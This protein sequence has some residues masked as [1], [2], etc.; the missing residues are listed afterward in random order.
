MYGPASI[1]VELE[2]TIYTVFN[3][4][5]TDVKI[6]SAYRPMF[7]MEINVCIRR[8]IKQYIVTLT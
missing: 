1:I 5:K 8:K 3:Y 2:R 6:L 4:A 7:C